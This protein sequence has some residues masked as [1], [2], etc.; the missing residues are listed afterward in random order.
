MNPENCL[1]VVTLLNGVNAPLV[2]NYQNLEAAVDLIHLQCSQS[3]NGR[4]VEID[5]IK[6]GHQVNFS[7]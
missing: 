2:T 7:S 5:S 4:M 3:I 6:R 1:G